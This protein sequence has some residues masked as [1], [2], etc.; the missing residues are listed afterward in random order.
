M[1]LITAKRGKD[2]NLYY[3]SADNELELTTV[4]FVSS[5]CSWNIE[6]KDGK[7]VIKT[8]YGKY[9]TV[10]GVMQKQFSD[11]ALLTQVSHN[12]QYA[13]H[14]YHRYLSV[15]NNGRVAQVVCY[16]DDEAKKIPEIWF[17]LK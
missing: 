16:D 7:Y 12:G 8:V 2:Y 10:D 17:N 13:F 11:Q 9:L 15:D 14:Y 1:V 6:R 3:S 5:N 4:T